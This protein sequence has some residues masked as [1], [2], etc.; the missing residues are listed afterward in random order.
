MF[1]FHFFSLFSYF[2]FLKF[3]YKEGKF[4]LISWMVSKVLWNLIQK[5]STW[6]HQL[7]LIVFCGNRE[8]EREI[9]LL[10]SNTR[11]LKLIRTKGEQEEQQQTM[12]GRENF[13]PCG[14]PLEESHVAQWFSVLIP[15]LLQVIFY[16]FALQWHRFH[17]G[18][19]LIGLDFV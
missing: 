16:S 15:C 12:G 1:Q 6:N 3:F 18:S 19:Q 4:T 9:D 17:G 14:C 10:L 7:F 2:L 13:E 5:A 11:A 8:R